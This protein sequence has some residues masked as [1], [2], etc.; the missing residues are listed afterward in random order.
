MNVLITGGG[1]QLAQE[2]AAMLDSTNIPHAAPARSQLDVTSE[3]QIR[4]AL[5]GEDGESF[6][7]VIHAA[8]YAKV[9]VAE[10][11]AEEAFRV[12]ALATRQLAAACAEREIPLLYVSTDYVF[13]GSKD[14]PYEVDDPPAPLSV[15]GASKLAGEESVRELV[16]QSYVVR[17]AGV[18]G[19]YG[20]NFPRAILKAAAA[21]GPLRVVSDQVG[22]P[23]YARDLAE[24][25]LTL[26]GIPCIREGVARTGNQEAAA[27][28]GVYHFTNEGNCSWFRFAKEIIHQAG[29]QVPISAITSGDLARAAK[30]PGYSALSLRKLQHLGIFP[31]P[32][33]VALAAFLKE[34]RLITPELFPH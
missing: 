34:L 19:A 6:S 27:P 22:S 24:G 4:S 16:P 26:L 33:D 25:I 28:C 17:T 10:A 30:R 13:S 32:W 23:T 3:A 15:Y 14:T 11:E 20:H 7:T 29:W 31:R 2:L 9:D 21:G 18:F 8:A 12:N 5:A 1:G